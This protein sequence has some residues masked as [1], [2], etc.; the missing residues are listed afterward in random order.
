VPEPSLEQLETQLLAYQLAADDMGQAIAAA[1]ALREEEDN[2]NLMLALECAIAVCYMRA[3][4]KS[5]LMTMPRRFVPSVKRGYS[6]QDVELH[7]WF[8]HRRDTAYAHT[9]KE[10]GRKAEVHRLEGDP[11]GGTAWHLGWES[12]PRE[13]I[14]P[15][16]DLF[17]RQADLFRFAALELH[18]KIEAFGQPPGNAD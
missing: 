15:A 16:I 5:T 8:A 4:T 1:I 14:N 12:F 13:W 3:F 7:K 10:S 2:R 18:D 6:E 11:L 9:D 17:Q